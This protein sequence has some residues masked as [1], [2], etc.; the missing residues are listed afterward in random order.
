MT[1]STSSDSVIVSTQTGTILDEVVWTTS[2]PG[3]TWSLDP[4]FFDSDANNDWGNWCLA[5]STFVTGDFGSPWNN[6][7]TCF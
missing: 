2:Y 5:S 6:N 1:L 4:N 7:P 3:Y